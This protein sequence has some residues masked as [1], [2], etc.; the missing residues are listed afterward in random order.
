MRCY[1]CNGFG[2]KAQECGNSRRNQMRNAP[3]SST[4]N[5]NESWNANETER[6]KFHR[7]GIEDKGH[8]QSWMKKTGHM[9]L[10]DYHN[11]NGH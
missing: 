6:M 9:N 8:S 10:G 2:H 5:S 3:Y 1:S 4:R 7:T 11:G